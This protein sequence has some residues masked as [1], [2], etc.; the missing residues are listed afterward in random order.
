M[1][2]SP[3]D[4]IGGGL[5]M[6]R[7]SLVGYLIVVFSFVAGCDSKSQGPTQEAKNDTPAAAAPIQ[8]P[9]PAAVTAAAKPRKPPKETPEE[10][11]KQLEALGLPYE[12][13]AF[14]ESATKGNAA[15]V[16]HFLAA[17]MDPNTPGD[18]KWTA[19]MFAAE[20]GHTA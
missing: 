1:T 4:S 13:K 14:F 9:A 19:L 18:S 17:G 20:K 2:Q 6:K 3:N 5:S 10:A 7:S 8:N 11:H 15:A 12:A 16:E